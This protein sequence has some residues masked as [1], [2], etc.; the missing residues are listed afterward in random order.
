MF[1]LAQVY[2]GIDNAETARLRQQIYGNQL[3]QAQIDAAN[4]AQEREWKQQ[5]RALA[6]QDRSRALADE[7]RLR[8]A[9]AGAWS[10]DAGSLATLATMD[11]KEAAALA[12]FRDARMKAGRDAEVEQMRQQ[13]EMV[14]KAMAWVKAAGDQGEAAARYA[15]A[16]ENL[17]GGD[18]LPEQFD[19]RTVDFMLARAMD[20][21]SILSQGRSDQAQAAMREAFAP[22]QVDPRGA[23]GAIQPSANPKGLD[24]RIIGAVDS[25]SP[26]GAGLAGSESGGSFSA[27][28]NV[29]G[30][31]GVG[32]FGRGQ[33]SIGRLEDA[34]RA[35]VI[36]A[37]MTPEQF[38]ASPDAQQR[39]EQWHVDDIKRG[40]RDRGFDRFIGQEIGGVPVTE[41]GLI[42]VAHLG[43][44]GGLA[45]FLQSGGQY[46]PADANGT[47]LSDYLAMGAR[48]AQAGAGDPMS[49]PRVAQLMAMAADPNLTEA[50]K[51][52]LGELL[53]T[54]T[55]AEAPKPTA[56]MQNYQAGLSDPGFM[57][58]LNQKNQPTNINVNTGEDPSGT[59]A[60]YKKLDEGAGTNI[61]AIMESAPAVMRTGRQID[62][63][64]QTLAN[65]PT[66][67]GAA[68]KQMAGEWGIPT[69]GLSDIQAAQALI[70]QMVPGQR[71]PGSGTMSDADLALFKA[72]IPRIINQPG[73]NQQIIATMRKINQYDARMVAIAN[74]VANREMTPSEGRAAMMQVE[75]PLAPTGPAQG[76]PDAGGGAAPLDPGAYR[77][78][79]ETGSLDRM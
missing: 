59:G 52:M 60:F 38:T 68:L 8:G 37:D 54:F 19:P 53:K 67:G 23:Q 72:S 61:A 78:N 56:D 46:D 5:D 25:Q 50:Q 58:Y 63:L 26:L 1:N 62:I 74:A 18:K 32:H 7:Q 41:Q 20:T 36:P 35:G 45:Q 73:G 11:P 66:G 47:R 17:D 71:A 51:S 9:R 70:N 24:P 22:Q 44:Q 48:D 42:N 10:G 21:D 3:Q 40:I 75:N 57:G 43:G 12:E 4:A 39:V 28:N 76:A 31:G 14:G 49:N 33:F 16:R 64:E 69:D 65:V 30:S 79:P 29:P 2:E 13:T 34:K 77:Y 27:R 15:M 6:Q 55:P